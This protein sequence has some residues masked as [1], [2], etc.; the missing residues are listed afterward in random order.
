MSGVFISRFLAHL[1]S[2]RLWLLQISRLAELL[3]QVVTYHKYGFADD[4]KTYDI[5]VDLLE[6][7]STFQRW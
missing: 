7:C 5:L 1:Q 4:A 3:L 2:L 6:C